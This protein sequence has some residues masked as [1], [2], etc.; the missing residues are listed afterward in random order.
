MKAW[1]GNLLVGAVMHA[2]MVFHDKLFTVERAVNW[3]FKM[4][5]RWWAYHQHATGTKT[6]RDNQRAACWAA[7]MNFVTPPDEAVARGDLK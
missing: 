5:K 7:M 1:L 6:A 3:R 4:R 2:A